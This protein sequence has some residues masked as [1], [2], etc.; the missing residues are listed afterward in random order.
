MATPISGG[1]KRGRPSPTHTKLG[2]I[3]KEHGLRA[4]EL[5]LQTGI[6]TRQ[7][8]ELLAGRKSP[9]NEEIRA[10]C[11]YFKRNPKAFMEDKYPWT[12]E[13][14]AA[15]DELE[16]KAKIIDKLKTKAG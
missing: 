12:V 15:R 6:Y 13:D 16:A 1:E 9:S 2:R 14:Q 7:L 10:L 4:G 5:T 8:T 3:M 11:I